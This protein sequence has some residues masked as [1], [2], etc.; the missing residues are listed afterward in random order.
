MLSTVNML[1]LMWALVNMGG[2][3]AK[4]SSYHH[5]DLRRALLDAALALVRERGGAGDV[6]LREAARRAGVSHNAP[7]R[8]FADKGEILAALAEEGFGEL[9]AALEAARANEDDDAAR[10]VKT[11]LAYLRFAQSK[12][13]HVAVMFGPHVAKSRTPALQRAANETFQVLKGMADD[14]GVTAVADARRAGV[15]AWSLVH[16][17]ATLSGER[18]IPVSVD[19]SPETLATMGLR[20]LFA[21]LRAR[22]SEGAA[23]RK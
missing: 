3:K 13:A 8:H 20:L 9:R 19:A 16:G 10:F 7:Y 14:A 6:T 5:G 12:P 23:P 11:G 15:V 4:R 17:V 18:Q 22:A 1:N 21:S 2:V